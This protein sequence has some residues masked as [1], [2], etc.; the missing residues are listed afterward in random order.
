MKIDQDRPASSASQFTKTDFERKASIENKLPSA[1]FSSQHISKTYLYYGDFWVGLFQFPEYT[2][3]LMT[4]T[5]MS[6][7]GCSYLVELIG[8]ESE[9]GKGG[10]DFEI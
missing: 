4:T 8:I 2:L 10:L 6:E 3:E 9:R 1:R 7:K 5:Y